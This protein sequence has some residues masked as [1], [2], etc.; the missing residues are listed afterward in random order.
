MLEGIFND[1]KQN[2]LIASALDQDQTKVLSVMKKIMRGDVGMIRAW[3]IH[4]KKWMD[5][6]KSIPMAPITP[7]SGSS[8]YSALMDKRL[9]QKT[10]QVP[11]IPPKQPKPPPYTGPSKPTAGFGAGSFQDPFG[12]GM[13]GKSGKG[14][15]AGRMAKGT[16]GLTKRVV[17][18]G[19]T[20]VAS[21]GISAGI[22][23][24]ATGVVAAKGIGALGKISWKGMGKAFKSL[25]KVG[26]LLLK[27]GSVFSG[28]A[29]SALAPFGILSDILDGLGGMLS[30]AFIPIVIDLSK[31]LLGFM[32]T[33]K[34]FSGYISELYNIFKVIMSGGDASGMINDLFLNISN[35]VLNGIDNLV[36][37][38]QTSAPVF[39]DAIMSIM[40]LLLDL[41]V[42]IAPSILEAI[43]GFVPV[44]LEFIGEAVPIIVNAITE[45]YPLL[46]NVIIEQ[47]PLII[48]TI[49]TVFPILMKAITDAQPLI[50]SAVMDIVPLLLE[51]IITNIPLII[52]VL[53]DTFKMSF[54]S[55]FNTMGEIFDIFGE[56]IGDWVRAIPEKIG[57]AFEDISEDFITG[58]KKFLGI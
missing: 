28:F 34:I 3:N 18:V 20:A 37:I 49:L 38:F 39:L 35:F 2:V 9:K 44:L 51:L 13:G 5:T 57:D 30:V 1:M 17:Q 32:P 8:M 40:S 26:G 29:S 6:L 48:N 15:L 58:F 47:A 23:G 16:W 46:L 24:G 56:Q 12:F 22:V 31:I 50:M 25:M 33:I 4:K 10:H 21:A 52:S 36:G 54:M 45:L 14:S 11:F 53:W 42:E 41:I 7:G 19:G 43:L 55:Y 27:L